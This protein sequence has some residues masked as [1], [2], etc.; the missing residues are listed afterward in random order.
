MPCTLPT[1]SFH[2]Y[3]TTELLF[4]STIRISLYMYVYNCGMFM[5][6]IFFENSY[7]VFLLQEYGITKKEKLSIAMMM[8]MPLLRK[9]QSD[10]NHVFFDEHSDINHRFDSTHCKNMRPSSNQLIRTRLYFTSESHIHCMM[11]ILKYGGMFVVSY[12]CKMCGLQNQ[13]R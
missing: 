8:C 2:R 6:S 11:N 13:S 5:G 3:S 12:A 9:I 7:T 4:H 10:L 1:L